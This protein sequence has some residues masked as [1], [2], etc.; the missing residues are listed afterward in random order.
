MANA[1]LVPT[2]KYEVILTSAGGVTVHFTAQGDT[3]NWSMGF[4]SP[5]AM[6][7]ATALIAHLLAAKQLKVQYFDEAATIGIITAA[8]LMT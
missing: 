7:R 6:N 4:T 8:T 5:D 2:G 3:K 1:T